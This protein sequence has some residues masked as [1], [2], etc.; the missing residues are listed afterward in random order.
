MNLKLSYKSLFSFE[1]G[2]VQSA[3]SQ[4]KPILP[5]THFL[6]LTQELNDDA[7]KFEESSG[8]S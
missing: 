4:S 2:I 5:W 7:N 3:I 1:N 8:F 6:V